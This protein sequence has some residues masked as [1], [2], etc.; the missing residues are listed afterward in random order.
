MRLAVISDVHGNLRA[1]EAMLADM[2]GG[3]PMRPSTSATTT[4]CRPRPRRRN[5]RADW[6]EAFLGT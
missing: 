5:G 3:H 2:P 1:L 6:A 4:G